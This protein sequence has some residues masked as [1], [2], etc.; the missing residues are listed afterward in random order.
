MAIHAQE[1]AYTSTGDSI[2]PAIEFSREIFLKFLHHGDQRAFQGSLHLTYLP[3]K[4]SAT[5]CTAYS[6]DLVAILILMF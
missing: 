1:L 5:L 2:C 3:N 4:P 6:L